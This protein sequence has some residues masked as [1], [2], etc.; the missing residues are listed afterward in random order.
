M[1]DLLMLVQYISEQKSYFN[2]AHLSLKVMFK[3]A[4]SFKMN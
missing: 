2:I 4:L 1:S 3:V